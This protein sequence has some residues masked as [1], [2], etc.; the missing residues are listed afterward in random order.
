MKVLLTGGSKGLGLA[1]VA[2]LLK[3]G[4]TV[5]TMARKE[6][7]E[8]TQLRSQFPKSFKFSAGD[9]TKEEDIKRFLE[10]AEEFDALI[11]NVGVGFDG[12]LA[13]QGTDS[14]AYLLDLNLKSAL[15]CNKWFIRARLGKQL[16][17]AI[18]NIS[19]I[20]GIRGYAGL[21]AYSATKAGLLGMTSSLARELGGK[22]F[23]VNAISPGYLETEMTS[24][25]TSAQ[26]DQIR[27]RTPL[28]RLGTPHDVVPLIHFL[29]SE[30]ASFITGQNFV[31][32]GGITC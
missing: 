27:R 20:I 13:T 12:L 6:T 2:D 19:S 18:L 16:A 14:I 28:N 15:L 8:V 17:G 31:I 10:K 26:M 4:H 29:L 3:E 9:F 1:I 7:K 21:A 24:A 22:G 32:D 30:K 23:R 11:N 5:A 25:L